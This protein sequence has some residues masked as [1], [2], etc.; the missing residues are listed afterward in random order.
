MKK[1]NRGFQPGNPY[2]ALGGRAR[3]ERLPAK[4]R[5]A[6]AQEG[7]RGR[8]QRQFGGDEQAAKEYMAELGRWAGDPY[9]GDPVP[10]RYFHPG[11]VQDWLAKRY[12]LPLWELMR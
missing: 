1:T 8:V 9:D 3:A 10:R 6:I 7:W 4:R 2:A 11:P 12:T 5:R